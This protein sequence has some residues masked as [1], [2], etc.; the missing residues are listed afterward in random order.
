MLASQEPIASRAGQLSDRCRSGI[1]RA[2]QY[3]LAMFD[4]KAGWRDFCFQNW[5]PSTSWV[6]AHVLWR[7]AEVL[8]SSV[9]RDARRLLL[10][11]VDASGGWGFNESVLPDAD[12][13]IHVIRALCETGSTASDL[14]ASVAF[15]IKHQSE[16]G[17]IATYRDATELARSRK[18]DVEWNYSGWTQDHQCVTAAFLDSFTAFPGLARSENIGRALE[19]MAAHQ[20][21]LGYWPSY[22][23]RSRVLA[24]A[25]ALP[26]FHRTCLPQYSTP[27]RRGI[28]WLRS[29]RSAEGAW[30]NGIDQEPS[31]LATAQAAAM[32]L[33]VEEST[34]ELASSVEWLLKFQLQDGSWSS[35]P[36]LQVPAPNV[37]NPAG[38]C[39]WRAGGRGI[40]SCRADLDRLYTTASVLSACL[41]FLKALARHAD[42]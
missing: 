10:E 31:I 22:W 25:M 19:F 13:S 2:R 14:R 42:S 4:P 38:E 36:C 3:V 27:L 37:M 5:G 11:R 1:A 28:A 15:V 40:G 20:S 35:A 18:R 39:E 41:Q 29:Q 16:L 30:S 32:L 23:W 34:F 21:G 33:S 8:P 12:S 6:T 9:V 17:G 7:T 24:T 26:A